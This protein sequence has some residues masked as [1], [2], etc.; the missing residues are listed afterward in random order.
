MAEHRSRVK[1][2]IKSH[3]LLYQK[4]KD[5]GIENFYIELVEECPCGNLEQLRKKESEYI[6]NMGTLNRIISGRTDKE[7]QID[8][9]KKIQENKKIYHLKTKKNS[10][11]NVKNGMRKTAKKYCKRIQ[12]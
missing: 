6:R 3:Y 9:K 2:N 1:N 10:I 5:L 4:M 12:K 11:R 8:N 7:Y